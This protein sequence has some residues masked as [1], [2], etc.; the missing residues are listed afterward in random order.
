MI[1]VR[2]YKAK[3][4]PIVLCD[5]CGKL[6][7]ADDSNAM[8]PYAT[9]E[10]DMVGVWHV[11]KECVNAFDAAHGRMMWIGLGDHLA[12]LENNVG[13]TE[14]PRQGLQMFE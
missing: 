7:R 2:H 8:Y 13:V 5:Q 4:F 3:T 11:H 12:L 1:K 9:K 10:D 6:C 14:K